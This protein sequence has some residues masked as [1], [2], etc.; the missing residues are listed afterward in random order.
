MKLTTEQ[1]RAATLGAR[2]AEENGKPRFDRFSEAEDAFYIERDAA[3]G[4][5]F[6]DRVLCSAG[7]KLVFKTDSET[8]GLSAEMVK[9][10][11]RT[12][13]AFDVA[14]NGKYLDSLCNFTEETLPEAYAEAPFSLGAFE[15]EF[16][17]GAGEKTVSVYFPWSAQIQDFSLTLADGASFVPV[18]PTKRLLVYGDSITQGYDARYPVR[19][20][21]ARLAE[22]LDAEEINKAIGGEIF[23]PALAELSNEENIDY[24]TVAYGTNDWS[25]MSGESFLS[26]AKA[27][28]SALSKRYPDAKIF[29]ITPIW[30]KNIEENKPFGPFASVKE[31]ISEA[32]KALPN[33]TLIDGTKLV[34]EDAALFADLCLHP[35]DEGFDF[36]AENLI[37]KVKVHIAE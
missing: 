13:F 28:Y 19:R 4:R 2:V 26:D 6:H 36:Y 3:L 14:V 31:R 22:A 33:V 8:L 30:R 29:A 23:C 20:Y 15:K 1:L 37:E 12:Y 34:P 10:S 18:K 27:F 21:A 9:R 24:I 32:T 16:D 17:L 7:V 25:T 5:T 11:S 35:K